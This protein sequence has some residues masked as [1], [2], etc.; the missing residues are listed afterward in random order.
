MI[1]YYAKC[2]TQEKSEEICIYRC[3]RFAYLHI[4][5]I[6]FSVFFIFCNFLVG[7]PNFLMLPIL[8]GNPLVGKNAEKPLIYAVKWRVPH[9][10]KNGEPHVGRFSRF[11]ELFGHFRRSVSVMLTPFRFYVFAPLR[12]SRP[13]AAHL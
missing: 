10:A 13:S 3:C 9:L 11:L 2:V 8:L 5:D 12:N 4:V 1:T 6:V 7:F